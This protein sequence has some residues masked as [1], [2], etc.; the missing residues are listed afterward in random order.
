VEELY[1]DKIIDKQYRPYRLIENHP[2]PG[3]RPFT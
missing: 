2:D 1:R 3:N